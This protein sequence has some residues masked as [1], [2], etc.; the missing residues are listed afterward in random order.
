MT[1]PRGGAA[2]VPEVPPGGSGSGRRLW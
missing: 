1:A 2:H